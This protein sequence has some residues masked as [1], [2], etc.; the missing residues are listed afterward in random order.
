MLRTGKDSPQKRILD[1]GT[2][3]LNRFIL[4]RYGMPMKYGAKEAIW[5]AVLNEG[6]VS[7]AAGTEPSGP[8]P[9]VGRLLLRCSRH[10]AWEPMPCPGNS[11]THTKRRQTP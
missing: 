9:M 11:M 2:Y 6:D 5:Q 7:G 4:P 1:S 8:R 10:G 3:E